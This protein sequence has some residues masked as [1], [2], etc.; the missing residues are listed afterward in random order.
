MAKKFKKC[1]CINCI[2][3]L[4]LCKEKI[5][6]WFCPHRWEESSFLNKIVSRIV[7]LNFG[8]LLFQ[9]VHFLIWYS[10]Y[11]ILRWWNYLWRECSYSIL[12]DKTLEYRTSDWSQP[13]QTR[14]SGN[15]LKSRIQFPVLSPVWIGFFPWKSKDI[16][17]WYPR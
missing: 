8:C 7:C 10:I 17:S 13:T 16:R 15:P 5:F 12:V 2:W 1:F 11:E 4:V 9:L 14:R 6:L 3:L